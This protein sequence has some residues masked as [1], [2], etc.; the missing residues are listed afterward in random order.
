[1]MQVIS[2]APQ[3]LE[4]LKALLRSCESPADDISAAHLEN[5][6]VI[7]DG[8]QI[9]GS[10]GLEKSGDFGLLR[11]L[12]LMQSLRGQGLGI[13]LVEQIEGYARSQQIAMLY[14]LTTTADQKFAHLKYKKI[15]RQSAPS[16]LQETAEIRIIC[17]ASAV[18]MD[19]QL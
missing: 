18:Y 3:D 14:V 10:I 15:P 12:A 19:R 9:L 4:S 16:P 2:A 8:S 11:S 1:M 5:F 6:F 13:Q 7:K 17:P